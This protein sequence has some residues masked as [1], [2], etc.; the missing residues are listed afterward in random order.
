M[1]HDHTLEEI[2][3]AAERRRI[4]A[5]QSD[6]KWAAEMLSGAWKIE[7]K[8]LKKIEPLDKGDVDARDQ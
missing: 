6:P 4:A 1:S 8:E 7:G 3:E 5:A 2:K